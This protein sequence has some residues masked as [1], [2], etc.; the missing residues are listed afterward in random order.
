MSNQAEFTS[1]ITASASSPLRSP[2][3]SV[4]SARLSVGVRGQDRA[5]RR[6]DRKDHPGEESSYIRS[7]SKHYE[8][9]SAPIPTA[10]RD[11]RIP[12]DSSEPAH[13]RSHRLCEPRQRATTLPSSCRAGTWPLPSHLLSGRREVTHGRALLLPSCTRGKS[14]KQDIEVGAMNLAGTG[15]TNR[16][17]TGRRRLPVAS[18]SLLSACRVLPAFGRACISQSAP[19]RILRLQEPAV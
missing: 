7:Y 13:P 12:R 3:E 4:R 10:G 2:R 8:R 1:L 5:L 11:V 19:L 16:G 18:K 14:T 15:L 6:G 17:T 9:G